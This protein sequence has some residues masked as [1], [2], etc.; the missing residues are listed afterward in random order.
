ME[1]EE[2]ILNTQSNE[3]E[4]EVERF[5]EEEEKFYRAR[6]FVLADDND[7]RD[8]ATGAFICKKVDH[9]INSCSSHPPKMT[10]TGRRNGRCI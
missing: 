8:V 10:K 1:K 5:E 7:W 2:E 6:V 4:K 9:I 3:E